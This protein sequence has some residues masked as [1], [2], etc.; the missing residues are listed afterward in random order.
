MEKI[1]ESMGDG[2]SGRVV[3]S[4]T[5]YIL[6]SDRRIFQNVAVQYPRHN[7][8]H[9]MVIQYLCGVSPREHSRYLGYRTPLP[10]RPPGHQ[11]RMQ[12]DKIVSELRRVVPKMDKWAVHHN[13]YISE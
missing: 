2:V 1:S 13:L 10:L 12:A 9:Y 7:S 4:Q 6:G 3:R 5:D 8:D 11:R